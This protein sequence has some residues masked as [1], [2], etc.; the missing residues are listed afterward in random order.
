MSIQEQLP[1]L[2]VHINEGR[3][4]GTFEL[5]PADMQ[6]IRYQG[7]VVLVLVADADA[8]SI[9]DTKD[10]DT[11]ASW[12]FKGV[13]A[14]IV[15][16]Q[17]MVDHLARTLHLDGLEELEE[18]EPVG[19]RLKKPGMIGLYGDEG[20]FLGFEREQLIEGRTNGLSIMD[21]SGEGELSTPLKEALEGEERDSTATTGTATALVKGTQ[22]E[23]EGDSTPALTDEDVYRPPATTRPI[24]HKD[25]LLERF[26]NNERVGSGL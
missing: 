14:A 3:V 12:T 4:S 22:A 20:E 13:D 23:E 18:M 17:G 21:P 10:G 9:K 8:I 15:R 24:H 1:G 5:P 26:L 7:R 2:N 16:D 25:P 6:H 11:K 19:T